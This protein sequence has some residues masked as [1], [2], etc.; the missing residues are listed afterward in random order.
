M[1]MNGTSGRR[2]DPR[3]ELRS[4]R[5]DAL[6]STNAELLRRP[7][8][9]PDAPQARALWLVATEQR[10]GRGRGDRRWLS[11]P[12]ASLTG[13]LGIEAPAMPPNP[14]ALSLVAGVAVAEALAEF[15][16]ALAL[17]WPNDL[18]RIGAD[19]EPLKVGGILCEMR[20]GGGPVRLVAGCGLN[21]HP[22]DWIAAIG[23]SEATP[24]AR[25]AG[26]V[27]DAPDPARHGPLAQALGE[28]LFVAIDRF[29]DEGL[30]PFVAGWRARDLLHGRRVVVHRRG[31]VLEGTGRGIDASGALLVAVAGDDRRLERIVSDE[32]SVRWR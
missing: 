24:L 26:T 32:V 29:L 5:V 9:C 8:L 4:E 13:S 15:G 20:G 22:A 3:S 19:G 27:F 12:Q 18:Y 6:D 10:Q 1:P 14:A 21:L 16:A 2:R 17:K 28:A 31:A 11:D 30:A 23:P 25:A 7:V